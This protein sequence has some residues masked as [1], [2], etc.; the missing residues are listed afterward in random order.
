MIT[1]I[2]IVRQ[3]APSVGG[4]E[5]AVMNLC[6]H[7][8]QKDNLRI[9]VVTLDQ[10]FSD[11]EKILSK[12]DVV[13]GIEIIRLPF[14]GSNRYPL[15]PSVFS[16]IKD[17]DLIHVHGI[18]FFFDF[19]ALT[20]P[21]HGKPLIASTHGGFF[22][23]KFAATLKKIYFQTVTRLSCLAYEVL[24]ASSENDAETFSKIAKR[25]TEILENGVNTEKWANASSMKPKRTMIF[26]G[27]WSTNKQVPILI[28]LMSHLLKENKEWR[29]IIAGI[30]S[31][32]T[33][34]SL[35]RYS[36]EYGVEDAI[37]IY[38]KPKDQKLKELIREASYI[39]SASAYEG[40]GLSIVE[41]LSAGLI[42]LL[43]PLPPFKKILE[44]LGVGV[45]IDLQH[46]IQSAKKINTNHLIKTTSH[47][48]QRDK[49]ISLAQH[50]AWPDTAER[51]YN[52]YQTVLRTIKSSN[53]KNCS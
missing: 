18:D 13:N 23:T 43:S 46:L 32:E 37:K 19:L 45:E 16:M 14:W 51:F 26:I 9:I 24:C 28:E 21:L 10:L 30:P 52:V 3:F 8:N 17:A 34:E 39:T 29:L 53:K 27:R 5:D 2:H 22:H 44:K 7:L 35:Q 49:C 36:R 25:K 42:P 6:Q 20:K 47:Q 41:G 38:E 11:P 50:Y 31:Y 40:F 15:A 48:I 33:S 1:V 12:K 4:L